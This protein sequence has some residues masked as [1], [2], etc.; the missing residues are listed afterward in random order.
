M[1]QSTVAMTP[2]SCLLPTKTSPSIIR[3]DFRRLCSQLVSSQGLRVLTHTKEHVV[4]FAV[5]VFVTSDTPKANFPSSNQTKDKRARKMYM[6]FILYLAA[7]LLSSLLQTV[8]SARSFLMY[9]FIINLLS[10]VSNSC[11]IKTTSPAG[12]FTI[13]YGVQNECFFMLTAIYN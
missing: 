2:A 8:G 9:K 5:T 6:D 13:I 12:L 7:L 4:A 11:E 1:C 10:F 3:S